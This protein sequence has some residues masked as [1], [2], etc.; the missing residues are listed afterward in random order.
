[1]IAGPL[2]GGGPVPGVPEPPPE[3]PPRRRPSTVG[4]V[5]YLVVVALSIVGLVMVAAGPWRR[6]ITLIGA[7]LVLAALARVL[8]SDFNSGMLRVRSK[9]FDVAA[10]AA[11]GALLIVLAH[12]IPNQPR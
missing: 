1:V 6:G 11:V 8:L 9:L 12:V 4:G 10:L 5:V 2:D 7:A 3:P